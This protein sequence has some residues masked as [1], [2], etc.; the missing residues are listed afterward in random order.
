MRI[1]K[2]FCV[3][4]MIVTATLVFSTG[5]QSSVILE[6]FR[7][8]YASGDYFNLKF[9]ADDVLDD[10]LH[11]VVQVC[12]EIRYDLCNVIPNFVYD[13]I[14]GS[15]L[16]DLLFFERFVL[17]VEVMGDTVEISNFGAQLVF[18]NN[19][20]CNFNTVG[21]QCGYRGDSTYFNVMFLG[22][23]S[24]DKAVETIFEFAAAP[25]LPVYD[26]IVR[27]P[28]PSINFMLMLGLAGLSF[29]RYRRQY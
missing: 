25:K 10:G 12:G 6:D 5:A 27:V 15:G 8:N 18:S 26:G 19:Y 14:V 1:I 20:R 16:Y 28:E 11:E 29:A 3:R 21:S 23:G 13:G 9:Y 4:L 24:N 7:I 22:G 2:L 17:T